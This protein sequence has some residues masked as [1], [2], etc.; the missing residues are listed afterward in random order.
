M[1]EQPHCCTEHLSCLAKLPWML[2]FGEGWPWWM[3]A[4][5]VIHLHAVGKMSWVGSS[6]SFLHYWVNT[7]WQYFPFFCCS[8]AKTW[9]VL[10]FLSAWEDNVPAL[11]ETGFLTWT[12]S[13]ILQHIHMSNEYL[14]NI[15][16]AMWKM[17]VK[18]QCL[19]HKNSF[20]LLF[21]V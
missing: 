5:L 7:F 8:V 2:G 18:S 14:W 15:L 20:S 21:L 9:L 3:V 11:S 17:C 12:L 13:R 10:L 16:N 6:C 19:N 1:F 4:H